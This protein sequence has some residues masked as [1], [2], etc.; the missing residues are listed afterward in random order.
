MGSKRRQGFELVKIVWD[1]IIKDMDY[2]QEIG[3]YPKGSGTLL[4]F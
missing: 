4:E 3:F 1:L 2:M